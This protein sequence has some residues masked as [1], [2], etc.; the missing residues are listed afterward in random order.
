LLPEPEGH[1][2]H[3]EI[4]SDHPGKRGQRNSQKPFA[5]EELCHL[6][7]RTIEKEKLAPDLFYRQRRVY[8]YHLSI[9]CFGLLQAIPQ[10]RHFPHRLSILLLCLIQE[11]L[12][13]QYLA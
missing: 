12:F 4:S 11:E 7:G 9:F 13:C 10:A 8:G 2:E 6:R 5:P 3:Q 1:S